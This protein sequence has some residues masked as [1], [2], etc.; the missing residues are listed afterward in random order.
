[1][2]PDP[3][4]DVQFVSIFEGVHVGVGVDG[5][6]LPQSEHFLTVTGTVAFLPD[7]SLA[8]IVNVPLPTFTPVIIQFLPL[9][10]TVK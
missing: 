6:G 2:L 8:V 1:M 7:P 3:L 4:H 10:L 5:P 9:A